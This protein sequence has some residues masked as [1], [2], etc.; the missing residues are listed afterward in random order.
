MDDPQTLPQYMLR[1]VH[2]YGDAKVAL[3]QKEFGIWRGFTWQDSYEQVRGW[4]VHG[5]CQP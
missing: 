1:Q 2:K 5:C 4:P 3:R